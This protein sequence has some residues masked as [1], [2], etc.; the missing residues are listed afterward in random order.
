MPAPATPAACAWKARNTG[1]RKATC[2]TSASTSERVAPK[3]AGKAADLR[4]AELCALPD[5]VV[6]RD[7]AGPTRPAG[8]RGECPPASAWRRM[9][10][11]LFRPDGLQ[12]TQDSDRR[13]ARKRRSEEHTS[14]IQS[15]MRISYAVF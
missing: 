8:L 14:E 11:P 7:L 5:R 3:S 1:S 2:C 12:A 4:G 6:R 9:P 15:L 13:L 10:P